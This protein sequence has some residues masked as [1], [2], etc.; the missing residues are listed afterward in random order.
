[1]AVQS[2]I[3]IINNDKKGKNYNQCEI[4]VK[5]GIKKRWIMGNSASVSVDRMYS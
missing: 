1:M 3:M 4:N 2:T 5:A